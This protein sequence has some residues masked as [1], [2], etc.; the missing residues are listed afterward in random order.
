MFLDPN[1]ELAR[2]LLTCTEHVVFPSK[3]EDVREPKKETN[4]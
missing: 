2:T 1:Q 4:F 3:K